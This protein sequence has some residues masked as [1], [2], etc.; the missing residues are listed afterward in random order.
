M[1]HNLFKDVLV[2]SEIPDLNN[3]F[4]DQNAS[5]SW[6]HQTCVDLIEIIEPK[7]DLFA[8]DLHG[9]V[10]QGQLEKYDDACRSRENTSSKIVH[11]LQRLELVLT[12]ELR[13]PRGMLG[14]I[15]IVDTLELCLVSLE[16]EEYRCGLIQNDGNTDHI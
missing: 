10:E 16:I 6:N 2:W 8:T 9:L 7:L 14:V 12:P 13:D 3:G 15:L 4:D 1:G 11:I 5:D